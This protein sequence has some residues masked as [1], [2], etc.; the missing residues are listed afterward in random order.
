MDYGLTRRDFLK[1]A[2]ATSAG[3]TLPG[4]LL[5]DSLPGKDVRIGVIGA[6]ARGTFLLSTLLSFPNV[7]I[8]AVC[9]ID[10]GSARGAQ[11]IVEK[12]TGKQPALYT[13]GETDWE[14]LV[15]R[16]DL[17]AVIIVTPWEYHAPMAIAAMR[18][19][20]FVGLEV[21]ACQTIEECHELIRVS[22]QTGTPCMLLENVNY[23]RNTLAITRMIREGLFGDI[24]HSEAGYQHDCRFLMF[25]DNGTLSW[26]G[27]HMAKNNGN[28]YPTHPIGPVAWWMNINRGNRF[29]RL[30]SVSTK[31]I[32]LKEYA[33]KKFG[34]DHPLA[35]RE[36][37]NG[38]TNTTLLE[39][40]NGE[41]VTLYFDLTTPRPSDMIFR[42]QGTRG[43]YEGNHDA[44]H[45]E[46][47]SPE[48]QWQNFTATFQEK[49]DHK[50]WQE[51]GDKARENGGH[52][53][54]DYI[55][56]HEFLRAL[57]TGA[58]PPIDVY[59]AVTW[60]AIVPLSMESV[61]KGGQ[62]IDFPDFTGGK[63]KTNAIV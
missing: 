57:R 3:A 49:Y 34:A 16:D 63:W 61:A 23:S 13:K 35:Q 58:K 10:L 17:D 45:L 27:K 50:L 33:R 42:V 39:T 12:A 26:R 6:G 30:S 36:Y 19:K 5:A 44:I 2:V 37:A 47:T 8:P 56:T 21:P 25:L 41:T 52:G 54:I 1:A 32:G 20:K 51:L 28:L 53:G 59:D 62:V 43:A 18:A 29:V 24:L 55:M 60:S 14:N 46:G 48:H 15:L 40:A 38:D 22:E 11:A 9:D 7:R 4:S 31:S